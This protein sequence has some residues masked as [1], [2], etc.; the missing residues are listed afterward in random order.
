[1][2][3]KIIELLKHGEF[4]I[5]YDDGVKGRHETTKPKTDPTF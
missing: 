5:S 3:Q 4:E 1:M 2:E